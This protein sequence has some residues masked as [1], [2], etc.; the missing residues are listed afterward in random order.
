TEGR[1]LGEGW[2][3]LKEFRLET[4]A[5]TGERQAFGS[6][7]ECIYN[8]TNRTVSSGGPMQMQ[9]ADGKFLIR[10]E[11]FLLRQTNLSVVISNKVETTIHKALLAAQT[12]QGRSE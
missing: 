4:F 6:S 12:P 7:P 3:L 8:I 2:V 5:R 10:G 1:A 11:G 9:T